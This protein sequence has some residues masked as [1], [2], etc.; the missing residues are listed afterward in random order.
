MN[1][2]PLIFIP[3][4]N[5]SE[6]VENIYIQIQGLSIYVDILFLDDNS[7]DGTGKILDSM[8]AANSN[9]YVIHRDGKKG[10]GSAHIEG[11]RWAYQN[12][13]KVLITMDCDFSHPPSYIKDF[14]QKSSD[15]D[16]IIGSRFL[17]TGGLDKWNPF[18]KTMTHIGHALTRFFLR[19]PY[20]ATGAFR[21]YRID[22]IPLGVFELIH[23]KGYSFFFQSLHIL[24]QNNF[25]I[26]EIPV[27]LS[28]RTYGESKMRLKD[29]KDSVITLAH[30]YISSLINPELFVYSKPFVPSKKEKDLHD[31]QGWDRY[32][33]LK[34]G[35]GGLVYDLIAV[36]Y[37]K[38]IIRRTLN[39]FIKKHFVR[40]ANI[41]HAGCGGGQVDTDISKW[42]NIS[43]MDISV[44]ALNF[45]K[46]NNKNVQELIHGDLFNI[47]SDDEQYD[48][49]YNLGVF[50]HFSEQDIQHILKELYRV[51]KPNG[52]MIIFWPPEF[53]LSVLF[54]KAVHFL[55]NDVLKKDVA[56]HP[57]EIAR[58]KSKKQVKEIF[59][60]A[61]LSVIE[62]YFGLRDMFTYSVIVIVKR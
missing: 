40:G 50:E 60:K 47:P 8:A 19:L 49:V 45:Y 56:L 44:R 38:F 41:L 5:E 7:P 48:G 42:I 22:K 11:I 58:V 10:I 14:I 53:G 30:T 52:K 32:W 61:N 37:R 28:A 43:A 16:V 62:Y 4:Y 46:K 31:K 51:V 55:L 20:D 9:I 36:F 18:R 17:K 24:F 25:A 21:L 39:Y 12:D 33:D 34:K 6:N 13:Y 15:Y 27:V 23:A 59:K 35:T 29:M 1:N 26:K 2:K 3:T 57:A 54:S